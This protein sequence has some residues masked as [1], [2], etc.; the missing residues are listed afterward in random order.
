MGRRFGR[1]GLGGE[2]RFGK[3]DQRNPSPISSRLFA[4]A[5]LPQFTGPP[6]PSRPMASPSL[7]SPAAGIG[8]I[9]TLGMGWTVELLAPFKQ[10]TPATES[11]CGGVGRLRE[12]RR[13]GILDGAQ[14]SCRSRRSSL[15]VSYYSPPDTLNS[16]RPT[17]HYPLLRRPAKRC[18]TAKRGPDLNRDPPI[19]A[20]RDHYRENGKVIHRD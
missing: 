17:P 20:N 3:Y 6:S 16:L 8:T 4:A 5:S 2:V 13:N 1:S 14:G 10:A 11:T 12:P 18:S 7:S 19:A 15:G 9:A